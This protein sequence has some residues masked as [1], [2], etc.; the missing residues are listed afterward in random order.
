MDTPADLHRRVPD[1]IARRLGAVALV[2]RGGTDEVRRVDGPAALVWDVL[3]RPGSTE[4]LIDRLT[5]GAPPGA[6]VG[7]TV[8]AGLAALERAGL[9]AGR[10]R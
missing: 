8:R 3:D 7:A 10:D 6:E 2:V 5:P 1:A 9:L 4:D